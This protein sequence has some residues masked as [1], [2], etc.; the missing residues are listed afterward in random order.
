MSSILL[1]PP[2]MDIK[3]DE[4]GLHLTFD[5]N[6]LEKQSDLPNQFV[7]PNGDL[8]HTQEELNEPLIDLKGFMNGDKVAT[9][10]AAEQVRLACLNHGFFQ[11]TNHGVPPSLVLAAQNE[12]DS[13]FDLPLAKKLSAQRKLGTVVGY[14]GAHSDRFASKLPWKE[15]FTFTFHENCNSGNVVVDYF[16][17]VLGENF[18]PTGC[19]Y[20][21]YCEAVTELALVVVELLAVSLG[22]DRQQ[23]RQFFE[24]SNSIMRCNYYPPC[25]N[26]GLTLGTGPHCDPNSITILH[27]DHVGG[28]EVFSD[29][30]W[31]LVRPRPH[32][33]VIN[34][35]DT[36]EALSNG[37]YKSCVH[38]AAVNNYEGRRSLAFFFSPN[39]DKVVR[40]PEDLVQIDGKRKYPDFTWSDM[41][42]FTNKHRR[43]DVKTLETFIEWLL[44]SK[45]KVTPNI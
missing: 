34:I 33:L 9:A 18:E 25:K 23:V 15:T 5:S 21:K 7:W 19:V 41:L 29:N 38:R 30:K 13:I 22:I 32:A 2:S 42:E 43:A 10:K 24:E 16:K 3:K 20:Q 37:K 31:R 4:N 12:I 40:A 17:T 14:S 44:S 35:G 1:C 6:K 45:A 28:L 26:A 27:Q 8:E 39:F 36:F 11:V